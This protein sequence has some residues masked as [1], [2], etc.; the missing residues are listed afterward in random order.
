MARIK[1]I[2][3]QLEAFYRQIKE[4]MAKSLDKKS[5]EALGEEACT[6]I[7]RRTRLGYGVR[8]DGQKREKLAP[9]SE[10]YKERRK[11]DKDELSDLTRPGKSNLTLTGQMIDSMQVL[12]IK[13]QSVD[14]GPTGTRKGEQVTNAEV[15]RYVAKKRPWL[16][17]SKLEANQIFRLWRQLF[18]D[19]RKK[20]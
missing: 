1:P 10:A 5:L 15:G 19:M 6:I 11:A 3:E 4:D 7:A 12:N 16:H 20:R 14:I 9:L 2:K 8:E 17:I 18:G 13:K